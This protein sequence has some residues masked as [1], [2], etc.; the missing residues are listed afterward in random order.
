MDRDIFFSLL[1]GLA[2][3]V[4][5]VVSLIVSHPADTIKVKI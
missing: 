5:C 1:D 2:G 3:A 4:S